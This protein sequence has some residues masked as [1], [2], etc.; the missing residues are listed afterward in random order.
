MNTEKS[1]AQMR[2]LSKLRLVRL[3]IRQQPVTPTLYFMLC[4]TLGLGALVQQQVIL[5]LIVLKMERV[6]GIV[7]VSQALAPTQSATPS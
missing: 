1:L 6:A 4:V 3:G 7:Q 2:H 5:H